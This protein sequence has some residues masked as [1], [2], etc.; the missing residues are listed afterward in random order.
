MAEK[1]SKNRQPS[2]LLNGPGAEGLYPE[3]LTRDGVAGE[4]IQ[5]VLSCLDGLNETE[6][7]APT[8][9]RTHQRHS[10]KPG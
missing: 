2:S 8:R 9:W 4:P 5:R 6:R 3:F 1:R 10:T 7:L